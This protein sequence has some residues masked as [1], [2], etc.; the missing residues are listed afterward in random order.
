MCEREF[1]QSLPLVRFV[2]RPLPELSVARI[3]EIIPCSSRRDVCYYGAFAF[4][5][6]NAPE[7]ADNDPMLDGDNMVGLA[8]H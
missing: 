1:V 6:V 5:H 2:L 4:G 8:R 3:Q 7:S